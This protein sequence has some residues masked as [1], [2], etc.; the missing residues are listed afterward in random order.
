MIKYTTGDLFQSSAEALVNTVNCEGY[1]GKGIAYQFKLKFPENNEDYIR[2]VKAGELDIGL[3]HH[4]EENGT[5]IINFPT[6]NKW[7]A[8]S[9]IEYIE[10]GLN[11]LIVLIEQLN[12]KSIAIPPLGSGNG[13]LI[14]H[15]V[16]SL[17]EKTLSIVNDQVDIYIYE[18]TK[19][20]KAK[21]KEEPRLSVSA[22]ILMEMKHHLHGFNKL[23]LQKTAFF[24][25]VLSGESYFKFQRYKYGPYD[26]GIHII[27]QNI[28]EFQDYHGVK[29]T[30]DAY[31][32]LYNKLVSSNVISRLE[33]LE[34]F[35]RE[36]AKLVNQ[37]SSDHKL[38]CVSTI[39]FLL[40]ENPNM[41]EGSIVSSFKAWSSD[42]AERF[43]ELEIRAGIKLLY[44]LGIIEKTLVGYTI[45]KP[46]DKCQKAHT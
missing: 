22:L 3:L 16:K 36:A 38:E 25:D 41:D 37:F 1:M 43:S 46:M 8:K 23:R 14:W 44:D 19:N 27:S 30:D 20:Y 13:G 32:I 28:K 35:V 33:T 4:F 40:V 11:A 5:I 7:R 45:S 6:K 12:I 24:M 15:E 42:K 2:A 10:K 29:K 26:N 17:M 31:Q 21:P 39:A 34:P 18:P 9:K